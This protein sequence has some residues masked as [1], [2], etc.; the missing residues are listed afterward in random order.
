M[1]L[2]MQKHGKKDAG[3]N[4]YT[5]IISVLLVPVVRNHVNIMPISQGIWKHDG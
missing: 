4:A 1:T 2:E 3:L 5:D